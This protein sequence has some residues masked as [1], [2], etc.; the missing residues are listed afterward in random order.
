MSKRTQAWIADVVREVEKNTDTA[1]CARILE[2][3][4]RHCAPSSLIQKTKEIYKSSAGVPEFLARLG[5]VFDALQIEDG[6]VYVVY[7]QCY[8]DQIKGIPTGDVPDA[9]CNCSVGWIRE[10]FEQAIGRPVK[11]ERVTTVISGG[12]ECR[13]R[14]VL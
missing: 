1:T 6:A 5:E 3:C 4:G 10:V 9:Y 8:C 12:D 13:F 14:V 7:P 2:S 11:V